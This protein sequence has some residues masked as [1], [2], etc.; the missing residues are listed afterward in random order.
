MIAKAAATI[1]QCN[2]RSAYKKAVCAALLAGL[3]VMLSCTKPQIKDEYGAIQVG[4]LAASY[5]DG[6][7]IAHYAY[8]EPKSGYAPVLKLNVSGGVINS[9][10]FDYYNDIGEKRSEEQTDNTIAIE[11]L[12][13]DRKTLNQDLIRKQKAS[14]DGASAL[15]SEWAADYKKLAEEL[16]NS[17]TKEY[18][19]PIAIYNNMNYGAVYTDL[20]TA[21]VFSLSVDAF[22]DELVSI[23]FRQYLSADVRAE[24]DLLYI[25]SFL[26]EHGMDYLQEVEILEELKGDIDA[27]EKIMPEGYPVPVLYEAFNTM[28]SQ[29]SE[30]A[31]PFSLESLEL[32]L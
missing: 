31:S 21:R 23:R 26:S 25:E 3:S 28:A 1:R 15:R 17:M 30:L 4:E 16:I 9:V 11:M 10:D 29:I 13:S 12:K 18:S 2:F 14:F 24:E 27:F 8:Y 20:A 19:G 22:G 5:K 32:S 6:E 7:Y